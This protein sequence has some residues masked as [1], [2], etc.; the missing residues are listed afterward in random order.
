MNRRSQAFTL[1]ELLVVIGI[2]AVLIGILLPTLG[3]AREAANST[4]CL[5]NMRQCGMALV[6]YA[7]DNKNKWL[8]PYRMP[9]LTQNYAA[10][11]GPY[12]FTWLSGKY[13]KEDPRMWICPSDRWIDNATKYF[14]L[15]RPDRD[16]QCSYILNRDMPHYVNQPPYPSIYPGPYDHIY[17]YHPRPLKW[18]RKPTRMIVFAESTTGY[19]LASYRSLPEAFRW[20]HRKRTSMSLCFADGHAEQLDKSEIMLRPGEVAHGPVRIRE[21]WYGHSDTTGIPAK[22]WGRDY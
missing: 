3:R 15:Y 11:N 17:F 6:F 22:V 13:Y 18:V 19:G 5:S 10:G 12:F 4:K 20:D 8:P 14:R 16:T 2:I 9:E 1:V 21:Y 7:S